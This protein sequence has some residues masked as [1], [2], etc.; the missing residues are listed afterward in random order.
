MMLVL[1]PPAAMSSTMLAPSGVGTGVGVGLGAGGVGDGVVGVGLAAAMS[2]NQA[3]TMTR[4]LSDLTRRP[5]VTSDRRPGDRPGGGR[6][7]KSPARI[8]H[9]A[10]PP[11]QHLHLCRVEQPIER[12]GELS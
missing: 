9:T 4:T 12:S 1:G 7:G 5:K 6:L 8:H 3:G 10:E 11:A 2:A